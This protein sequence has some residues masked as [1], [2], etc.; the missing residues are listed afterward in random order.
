MPTAVIGPE[1]F[2]PSRVRLTFL[3]VTWALLYRLSSLISLPSVPSPL[4]SLSETLRRFA[5]EARMSSAAFW[6]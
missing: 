6:S 5:I 4:A 2:R 3:I 1:S